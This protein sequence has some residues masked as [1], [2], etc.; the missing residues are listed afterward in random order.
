MKFFFLKFKIQKNL[1]FFKKNHPP[2]HH[3]KNKRIYFSPCNKPILANK[4]KFVNI[5]Y[6]VSWFVNMCQD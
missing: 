4:L 3:I 2:T 6:G 5:C 1:K